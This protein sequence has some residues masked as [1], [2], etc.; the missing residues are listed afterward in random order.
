MNAVITEEEEEYGRSPMDYGEYIFNT[1][2]YE[3]VE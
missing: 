1:D 2:G 3:V